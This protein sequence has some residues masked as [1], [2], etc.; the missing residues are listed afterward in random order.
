MCQTLEIVVSGAVK[1]KENVEYQFFCFDFD[2][3]SN[4]IRSFSSR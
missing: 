2:S 4:F 1:R 3:V